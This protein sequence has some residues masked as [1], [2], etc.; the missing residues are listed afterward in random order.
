MADRPHPLRV[1]LAELPRRLVGQVLVRLG[2]R[3]HRLGDRVLEP[4]PG[5]GLADYAEG[6]SGPLE[7]RE[8]SLSELAG[9]GDRADV[10]R[11]ERDAAVDQ[12][13]PVSDQLVVVAPDEL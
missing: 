1:G 8:V 3:A 12:I 4:R 9:V 7:Y 6:T 13:A 5:Q 11:G 10:A 2:E